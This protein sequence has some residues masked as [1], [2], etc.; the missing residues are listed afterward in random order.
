[1]TGGTVIDPGDSAR[2]LIQRIDSLD[3]ES[4]GGFWHA[5]GYELPW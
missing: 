5:E 4:S 3:L 1:M 2:G